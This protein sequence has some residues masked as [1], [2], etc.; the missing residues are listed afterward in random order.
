MGEGSGVRLDKWLT[1]RVP[2]RT[3]SQIQ[4]DLEAGHIKVND[5]IQPARYKVKGGDRIFYAIPAPDTERLKPESIPLEIIYEDE[6]VVVVN[7]PAGMVVHPAPGHHGG[8]LANALL[9]H[10][11]P[12][13]AGVGGEGRWGIVHRLD[14][15]T[16]GLMVAARTTLA[17]R[18][19][20]AAIAAREVSRRYLGIVVGMMHQDSGSIDKPL[21]RRTSDRKR[22]GV[23]TRAGQGRPSQTDWRVIV[24]DSGLALLGLTLHTGRTHQIRVHL[25]SI[26]RPILSDPDYGWTLT[27]TLAAVTPKLRPQLGAVWPG[28]QMLHATRLKFN[29]PAT[30]EALEFTAL[31]PQDMQ[32]V[33]DLVWPEK[34]RESIEHWLKS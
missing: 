12:S 6:H 27:R 13:L 23:M 15:Q 4:N 26:C 18:A 28:R 24:Q 1:E 31:P 22:I 25:E 2:D 14:A 9:A 19:L 20:T 32:A 7:K 16:S 30:G 8:T 3:R 10:C 33:M 5:A 11:G 34:W 21:G 29:H 17:F